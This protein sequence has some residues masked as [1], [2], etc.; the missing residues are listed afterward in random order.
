MR[1]LAVRVWKVGRGAS[2]WMPATRSPMPRRKPTLAAPFANC[3]MP[4]V[5]ATL[6][7]GAVLVMSRS[8]QRGLRSAKAVALARSI[9][10]GKSTFHSWGG[11]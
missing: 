2:L 4:G 7:T 3:P 10:C 9:R 8:R 11:R 6:N 5:E 1:L